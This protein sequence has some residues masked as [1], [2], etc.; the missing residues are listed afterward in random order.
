MKI[1]EN[2][3]HKLVHERSGAK[4]GFSDQ[5]QDGGRISSHTHPGAKH[6]GAH[7]TRLSCLSL[8]MARIT[9]AT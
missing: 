7:F 5:V 1:H 3:K 4:H 6:D 8:P 2:R 9:V